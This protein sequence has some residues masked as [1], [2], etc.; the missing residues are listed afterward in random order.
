MSFFK[1]DTNNLQKRQLNQQQMRKE[2]RIKMSKKLLHNDEKSIK[3]PEYLVPKQL[4]FDYY[5]AIG[6]DQAAARPRLAILFPYRSARKMKSLEKTMPEINLLNAKSYKELHNMIPHYNNYDVK[7]SL[8]QYGLKTYSPYRYS[9]IGDLFFEGDIAVFL[10]LI[11]VNTRY[12]YAYQLGKHESQ[13]LVES[14]SVYY[15][16]Y[17]IAYFTKDRKS[18][19]AIINAFDKHLHNH[20]MNMLRF[21]NE[22]TIRS[23][24]FQ[25]YLKDHNILFQSTIKDMHTSLALM[26]RLC[27]TIRDIAFNLNLKGIY[28]QQA[29]DLILYY[30]NNTAHDSLTKL[31]FKSNPSLKQLYP[32]GITPEDMNQNAYLENEYVKSCMNYNYKIMMQDDFKLNPGDIVKVQFNPTGASKFTKKRAYLDKTDY[33]VQGY[34]GNMLEL[35]NVKTG[36][37]VY[38]PRYQVKFVK[39]NTENELPEFVFK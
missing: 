31:I 32:S 21:D 28:N 23:K 6:G 22:A 24:N 10:L 2:R 36:E 30:Y 33:I 26:D 34:E 17:S 35:K 13:L 15:N 9:Y 25:K 4:S 27:R 39:R 14:P 18:V 29:M 8:K 7:K 19:E 38:K 12:V 5:D 3:I 16:K 1:T 20:K 37:I 11:N